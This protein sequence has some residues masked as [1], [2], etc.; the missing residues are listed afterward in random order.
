MSV[1]ASE[2]GKME[3]SNKAVESN[4]RTEGFAFVVGDAGGLKV[5]ADTLENGMDILHLRRQILIVDDE[6]VNRVM[7]RKMLEDSYGIICAADGVEALEQVRAHK[8]NLAMVLL[9]LRMPR[10]SGMEMLKVMKEE[11]EL[12]NIPVIVMTADQSAE[13]ECLQLGAID[14]IPKPYPTQ[15]IVHAR[16]RRCIELSEDR[17]IIQSTERDRLTSL[18]NVDYFLRYVRMFNQYYANMDM[19]AIVLDINRFHILNERYGKQYGDGVLVRIGGRIRT[20][21]R[22]VGGLCCRH[23][24][25]TFLIYCPHREDYGDI[26]NKASEGLVEEDV[27]ESRVRLR[28]GVYPK[29]DKSIETERCFDHAKTAANTVRASYGKAIGIYDA[30]MHEEELYRERLL[31]D[32][33]P[34]LASNRFVVYFQP[35]YDVR[36]DVPVLASAEALVR[37]DHPELGMISPGVF[38]PLLEENGLIPYLD[39]FVWREAAAR[40]R[41]WKDRLGQSVPVSVNVSRVDMLSPN[42]GEILRDIL[43]EHGLS[44]NDLML[45]ITES[46]YTGDSGQVIST[47]KDLRSM[48]FRI[49]MDDFGT[50][51]S[52]LG[53]ISSLPIDVLKLDMSF[54]RNA[55]GERRDVRMIE[56]IIDIADYL[57]VPVVAEG[58]ET[59]EQYTM[60]KAMGCDLVQGYY[61]SRPVPP[62]DFDRFLLECA[63][64]QR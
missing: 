17:S 33:K 38:I 23:G 6:R 45:E 62:A 9:D 59:E 54:V 52:S 35:K 2:V 53:M 39:Q 61:F 49:E 1:S 56:L 13:V 21:A 34:S 50:G 48:G 46:A 7:L 18:F 28:M 36:S 41:D 24:A 44:T 55:F 20:I 51:Y 26:L 37:W 5:T 14:F 25:D 15:E 11:G 3:A 16:V 57:C 40:I 19:D 47:A 27:S 29:V 63:D 22:E 8:D 32:F 12:E 30:K 42:L 31:E 60:L 4:G 10:M 58:V 43:E 64:G